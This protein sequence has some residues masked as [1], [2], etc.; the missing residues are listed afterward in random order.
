MTEATYARHT[1]KQTLAMLDEL[2]DLYL[3]THSEQPYHDDPIFSRSQFIDR[4]TDQAKRPGFELVTVRAGDT[5][6]GFSFG[7]PFAAGSWWAD[8]TMPPQHILRAA[9]FAVIEL[10]VRRV[11]RGQG[12][13]KAL[14][15]TLLSERSEPYATLAAIPESP[16]YAMYERWGW[17]KVGVFTD[18]PV[19]DALALP[20]QAEVAINR[21]S[22]RR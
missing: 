2:T 20:L 3:E 4:T 6:A 15:D 9:K 13:G 8:C 5:L 18:E 14:L 11:Y 16:A 17:Y 22:P 19:M 1:G 12:W 7:L 10:D 21:N